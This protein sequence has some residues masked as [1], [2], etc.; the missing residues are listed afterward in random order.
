MRVFF[1]GELEPYFCVRVCVLCVCH[2]F[3]VAASAFDDGE[4]RRLDSGASQPSTLLPVLRSAPSM[5]S[6]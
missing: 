5:K 3:T 1:Y 2:F 4:R 6:L